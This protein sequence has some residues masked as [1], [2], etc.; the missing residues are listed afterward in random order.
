MTTENA[1]GTKITAI[2]GAVYRSHYILEI[3]RRRRD[4]YAFKVIH[5]GEKNDNVVAEIPIGQ[6]SKNTYV[7]VGFKGMMLQFTATS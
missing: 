5:I 2:R 1:N 3:K 7:V 4:L 6:C